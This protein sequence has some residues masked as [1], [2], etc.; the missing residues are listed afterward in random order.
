MKFKKLIQKI[1]F[2]DKFK[3]NQILKFYSDLFF[4]ENSKST[5]YFYTFYH[6]ESQI[7]II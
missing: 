1:K 4:P 6:S 3:M 2:F 5:S 7:N